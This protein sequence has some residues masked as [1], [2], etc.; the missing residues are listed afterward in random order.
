MGEL[1]SQQVAGIVDQ[2]RLPALDRLVEVAVDPGAQGGDVAAFAIVR[3]V[4]QRLGGPDAGQHVVVD[5]GFHGLGQ[6][7]G[8]EAVPHDEVGML[9]QDRIDCCDRVADEV[10]AVVVG[11]FQ[12]GRQT[13]VI[14]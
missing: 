4:R 9:L 3:L 6:K 11:C 5:A 1:Q 2:H 13:G 10:Q 12:L 8:L 14:A 7:P